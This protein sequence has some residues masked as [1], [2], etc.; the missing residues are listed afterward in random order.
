M[1]AVTV[2]AILRVECTSSVG[3]KLQFVYEGEGEF[4]NS[5][6]Y[7]RFCMGFPWV[8][9]EPLLA[10]GVKKVVS[11]T[12]QKILGNSTSSMIPANN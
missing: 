6:D 9:R 4:I 3:G 10:Y 12:M 8:D 5:T 11:E 2:Q 1:I 7:A